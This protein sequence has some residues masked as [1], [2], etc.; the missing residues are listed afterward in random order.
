[1]RPEAH[2]ERIHA[3]LHSFDVVVHARDIDQCR[4]RIQRFQVHLGSSRFVARPALNADAAH[5]EKPL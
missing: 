4:G 5:A 3:L 1:V 2:A